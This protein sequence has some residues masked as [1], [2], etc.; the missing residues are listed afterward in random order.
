MR[1]AASSPATGKPRARSRRISRS[2]STL[3]HRVRLNVPDR[4]RRNRAGHAQ[5]LWRERARRGRRR[6][7]ERQSCREGRAAQAA[8]SAQHAQCRHPIRERTVRDRW[9][10]SMAV[11]SRSWSTQAPPRS[12]SARARPPGWAIA[13]TSA[14]SIK[15]H[16]A[17]GEGRAARIELDTVEV[18]DIMVRDVPALVVP[19]RRSASICSACRSC[20]ASDGCTSAANWCWSSRTQPPIAGEAI[21]C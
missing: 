4:A 14:T 1:S 6:A 13:R 15:I 3:P 11:P 19:T 17:N 7:E 9:L 20:R 2:F 5:P 8:Q 10:A 12:R 16:T 21:S 18:G